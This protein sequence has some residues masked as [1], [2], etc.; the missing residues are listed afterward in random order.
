M[1]DPLT[2]KAALGEVKADL[3]VKQGTLVNVYTGEILEGIDVAIKAS[4]IVYMGPNASH[5]V[6]S[7]TKL[8]DAEG[9]YVVPG[10]IDAH[11]HIDLYCTP[12]EQSKAAL[13]HGTTTLFAEPDQL[14][15]VLGFEGLKLFAEMIRQLPIKVYM[16]VPLVCPQDPL[17]DETHSLK[18]EEVEEALR[19]DYVVGLGEVVGWLRLLAGDKDY[20]TKITIAQRIGKIIEGH[21]AGAKGMKL[22]AYV[23][24]GINSC[25]EAINADEAL[26]RARLGVHVMVREGSLRQDLANVLPGLIMENINLCAVSLVTDIMDPEDLRELGY[27]DHVVRKAIELG[28]DPVRAIM[29][30]TINP[31]RRFR[32]DHEIGGIGPGKEADLVLLEN[33]REVKVRVTISKGKVAAKDGEVL[34]EAAPITYPPY[35]FDTVKVG[36]AMLPEDFKIKVGKEGEVKVRVMKLMNEAIN[37]LSIEELPVRRGEVKLPPGYL[38]VAV[39]DRHWET[40]KIALGIMEGFGAEVGG[41]AS[42]LNFDEN[43]L[44]VLGKLEED[45]SI[46]AN[47]IAELRGGI[48]IVDG[49]TVVYELPMPLAGVMSLDSLDSVSRR[50]KEMNS[51][52]RGKGS[53]LKKP[54]NVMAFI[55]FVTLP[56]IRLCPKGLVDVKQRKL[57]PLIIED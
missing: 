11:T 39:I 21:S 53:K 2:I 46:A 14:A 32:L 29:M 4:K 43:N 57:V 42:T 55:T 49:G 52:L 9:M 30:V 23:A 10:F 56:E 19:W 15:N 47:R 13:I 35:A 50:L 27:M 44:V 16:L 26:E 41:L 12:A 36:R 37:K 18:P 38:K 45:M 25:H 54:L 34:V 24:A 22:Q 20:E 3:V 33:L 28:V 51:Y 8:I 17:F 1:L 5:T 7:E 6:G 31:A 40:G 48:V